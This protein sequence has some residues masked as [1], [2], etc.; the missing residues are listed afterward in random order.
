MIKYFLKLVKHDRIS[1]FNNSILDTSVFSTEVSYKR[2]FYAEFFLNN[3]ISDF[4]KYFVYYRLIR[5]FTLK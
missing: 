3:F 5:K 4:T 2:S 1:K